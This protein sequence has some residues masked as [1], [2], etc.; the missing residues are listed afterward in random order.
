MRMEMSFAGSE[1]GTVVLFAGNTH[2]GSGS[3]S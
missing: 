1:A 2:N 3:P